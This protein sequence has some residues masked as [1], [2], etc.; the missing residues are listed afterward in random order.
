MDQHDADHQQTR[1]PAINCKKS[2]ERKIINLSGRDLTRDEIK[3][4][5]RGLKFTPTPQADKK[6]LEADMQEF[7][8]KLRLLEHFQDYKSTTEN[9]I[10][11][12][13]SNF[14]PPKSNDE[15]LSIVLNT[16]TAIPDSAPTTKTRNNI[17]RGETTA[18]RI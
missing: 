17:S 5:K 8:R 11:K 7:Q 4:L 6:G 14:V 15:Y 18:L 2:V 10:V 3:L 13:R 16:L 1:T 12:N 9:S